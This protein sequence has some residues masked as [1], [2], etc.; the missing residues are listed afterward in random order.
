MGM[1]SPFARVRH[2]LSSSTEFRFSIHTA[3]PG[4]SRTIQTNSPLFFK[5]FR[6]MEEKIPSVQSL[7]ATSSL[8]N[9]W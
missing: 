3:S 6:Q 1:R 5:A 4:P 9:I 2:L 8:P 7:V